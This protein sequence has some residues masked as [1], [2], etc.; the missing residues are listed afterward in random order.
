MLRD[1]TQSERTRSLQ[2]S[3]RV[4]KGGVVHLVSNH[5]GPE[6]Y[7]DPYFLSLRTKPD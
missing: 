3:K 2:T 6:K 5:L 4:L 7:R 1:D